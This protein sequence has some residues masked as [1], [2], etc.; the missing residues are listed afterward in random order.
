[1]FCIF[2]LWNI[3]APIRRTKPHHIHKE[4]SCSLDR[5]EEGV[6]DGRVIDIC[7]EHSLQL[8]H[9]QSITLLMNHSFLQGRSS[10]IQ[11]DNVTQMLYIN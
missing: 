9:I 7:R 11:G 8:C 1:M 3:L 5:S 4:C 2:T 6:V 10:A